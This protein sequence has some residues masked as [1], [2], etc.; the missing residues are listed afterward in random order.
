M[1][2]YYS[3]LEQIHKEL[4]FGPVLYNVHVEQES[5]QQEIYGKDLDVSF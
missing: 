3:S 1:M 2:L 5:Y 4:V